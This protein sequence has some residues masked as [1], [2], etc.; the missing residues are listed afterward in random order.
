MYTHCEQQTSLAQTSSKDEGDESL[1]Q[2]LEFG[3][4]DE[5]T[6]SLD[7]AQ[8]FQ[9][10]YTSYSEIPDT[11]LP[12]QFDWRNVDGYD[13]T[14]QIRDQKACGSCYTVAFTQVVESRLKI[15]Y[16]EEVP[17]LSPQMLLD[18]NYLTEGC[19]GGWPHF[20]AFFA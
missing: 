19:E 3:K 6:K 20:H 10:K 2:T 5:F 8:K 14:S 16:G 11:E 7:S 1:V 9:K 13:F 12:E 4:G 15:K 17:Q 18:C